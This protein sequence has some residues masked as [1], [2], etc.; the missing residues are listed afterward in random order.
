MRG[1]IMQK[2]LTITIDENVYKGLYNTIGE[3]KISK[4]IENLLRPHVL[5]L[6]LEMAYC[7]MAMDETREIEATDW[8]EGTIGDISHAER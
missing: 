1:N 5:P 3:G 7:E 8:I 4:F 2:K 6:D